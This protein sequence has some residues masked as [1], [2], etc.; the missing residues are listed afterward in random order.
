MMASRFNTFFFQQ[1]ESDKLWLVGVYW[2]VE[3]YFRTEFATKSSKCT[4]EMFL[5]CKQSSYQVMFLIEKSYFFHFYPPDLVNSKTTIPL[6]VG[7]QCWIY[8]STLRVSHSTA[9][10]F[11]SG[12]SCIL[13]YS[14]F[15]DV[16]FFTFLR[17]EKKIPDSLNIQFSEKAMAL[18]TAKAY[19]RGEFW[20][21]TRQTLIGR[22]IFLYA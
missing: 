1:H 11:S 17:K 9:I 22:V 8:T 10:H 21:E 5:S 4:Y 19:K 16:S 7:E 2:Q 14:N 15:R 3:N 6:R 12:D 18:K 13:F 20:H